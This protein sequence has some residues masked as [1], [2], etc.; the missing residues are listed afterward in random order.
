[1]DI[2]A[3]ITKLFV[4]NGMIFGFMLLGVIMYVSFK[5]GALTKGR[6]HGS[7]IAIF[8]GLVLAYIGGEMTGGSK[9]IAD[10]PLFSATSLS[11]LPLLALTFA[12]SKKSAGEVSL[13]CSSV[14][15][16]ASSQASLLRI[17]SAIPVWS[18]WS[19]SGQALR[20]SLSGLSPARLSVRPLKSSPSPSLPAL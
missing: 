7:A 10:V 4:K 8:L 2:A 15:S 19:P 11:F 6:V 20:P 3:M 18:I 9:G 17:R 16:S 5:L 12:K 14:N 13:P 1:M